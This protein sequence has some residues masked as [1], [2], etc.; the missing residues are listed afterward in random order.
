MFWKESTKESDSLVGEREDL[1]A[2]IQSTTGHEKPGGKTGGPSPKAK[3][4]LVTDRV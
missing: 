3:Y 4:D 2:S 1:Q